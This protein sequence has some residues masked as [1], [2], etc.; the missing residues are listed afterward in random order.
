[1]CQFLETRLFVQ[2]HGLHL[3]VQKLTCYFGNS[4]IGQSVCVEYVSSHSSH[5]YLQVRETLL[6]NTYAWKCNHSE[7]VANNLM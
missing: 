4:L 5:T 6:N 2:L 1:M 7:R 3:N